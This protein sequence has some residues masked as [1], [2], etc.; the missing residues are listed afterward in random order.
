[1]YKKL[2]GKEL[3]GDD[4]EEE[5]EKEDKDDPGRSHEETEKLL[6]KRILFESPSYRDAYGQGNMPR[7]VRPDVIVK[8]GEW[9]ESELRIR[10][11]IND[12]TSVKIYPIKPD[13]S[14]TN[15]IKKIKNLN[16]WKKNE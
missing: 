10:D 1:M 3:Q 11:K 9:T 6:L 16:S 7:E 2:Q 14:T 12:K 4:E 13:Y 8:G 5:E 15:V